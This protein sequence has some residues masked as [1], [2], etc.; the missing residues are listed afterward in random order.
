M[1]LHALCTLADVQSFGGVCHCYAVW[2][3][4]LA[5]AGLVLPERDVKDVLSHCTAKL[6]KLTCE[7]DELAGQQARLS[8]EQGALEAKHPAQLTEATQQYK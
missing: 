5:Q 3:V 8:E 7:I 1:W 2:C 6:D 4:G